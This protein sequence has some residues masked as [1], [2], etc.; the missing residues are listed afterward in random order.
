[1]TPVCMCCSLSCARLSRRL[2]ACV[3][4]FPSQ[5][6]W[7]RHAQ[8]APTSAATAAIAVK[9]M[10][11]TLRATAVRSLKQRARE[12]AGATPPGRQRLT[13]DGV[14]DEHVGGPPHKLWGAVALK[15]S[16]E[17][18]I[19][20]IGRAA[21]ASTSPLP[22]CLN[23]T[24]HGGFILP[25]G[26]LASKLHEKAIGAQFEEETHGS[27]ADS[28]LSHVRAGLRLLSRRGRADQLALRERDL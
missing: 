9:Q 28:C 15:T 22:S 21:N 2:P 10:D 13:D 6:R 27:I 3:A 7:R 20:E 18:S 8:V 26:A 11:P 14:G 17:P 24:E 5:V 1:M 19:L 23:F 25:S 16:N 12:A 4:C